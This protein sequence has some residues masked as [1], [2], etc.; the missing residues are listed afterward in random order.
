[1]TR[2]RTIPTHLAT[3]DKIIGPFTPRGLL[4]FLLGC[5]LGYDLW[6]HLG[7][8]LLPLRVMLGVL[9]MLLCLLL[10]L[11]TVAGR[12]LDVWCLIVLTSLLRPRRAIWWSVHVRDRFRLAGD[13]L[14]LPPNT[15]GQD[16]DHIEEARG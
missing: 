6:L 10:A 5:T 9:P 3:P 11:V 12:G 1:M 4:L 15:E 8:W 13:V 2:T 14:G 16:E 7:G